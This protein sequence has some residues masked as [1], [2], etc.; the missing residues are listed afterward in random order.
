MLSNE[1]EDIRSRGD[2]RPR[3]FRE[4]GVSNYNEKYHSVVYHRGELV[5]LVTNAG[6]VCDRHP[7]LHRNGREPSL[8]GAVRRKVVCVTFDSKTSGSKDGG[9]T[10]S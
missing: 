5:G 3:E 9:E 4:W 6:V 8:V 1:L 10:D 2:E 7:P